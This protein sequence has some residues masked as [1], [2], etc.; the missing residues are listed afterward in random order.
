MGNMWIIVSSSAGPNIA[1]Y[2]VTALSTSD[3][4]AVGNI[5]EHWDGNIWSIVPNPVGY[6]SGVTALSTNDVWVCGRI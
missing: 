4:W 5:I 6:L 1:F 3:V 2:A